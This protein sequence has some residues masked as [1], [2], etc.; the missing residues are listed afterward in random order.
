MGSP[1]NVTRECTCWRCDYPNIIN[2]VM[3]TRVEELNAILCYTKTLDPNAK[4]AQ[5]IRSVWC[6]GELAFVPRTKTVSD[7]AN[8]PN[9][10]P[11]QMQCS[12]N[13]PSLTSINRRVSEMTA[14]IECNALQP[15]DCNWSLQDAIASVSAS[16][17]V[18]PANKTFD[19][20]AMRGEQSRKGRGCCKSD[21]GR[22]SLIMLQ[23]TNK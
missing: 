5:D 17:D 23:G 9:N 11:R 14:S 12:T 20:L 10:K 15:S 2:Q 4:I 18:S 22:V 13:D 19:N 1:M 6:T 7:A 21:W 8:A 3:Q 16:N